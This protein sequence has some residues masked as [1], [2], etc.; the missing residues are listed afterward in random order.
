MHRRMPDEIQPHFDSSKPKSIKSTRLT[1]HTQQFAA[2][3][4]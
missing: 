3:R 2:H 1:R 4:Q